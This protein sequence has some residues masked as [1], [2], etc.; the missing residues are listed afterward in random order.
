MAHRV[1]EAPA[2]TELGTVAGLTQGRKAQP[3]GKTGPVFD[4]S[5]FANNFSC[6][7]DQTP[8]SNCGHRD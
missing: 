1:Y 4:G 8:G 7:V 3:P 2:L 5:D 6:V